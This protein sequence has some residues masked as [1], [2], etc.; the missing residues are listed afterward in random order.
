MGGFSF[1]EKVLFFFRKN[2]YNLKERSVARNNKQRKMSPSSDETANL[3]P[4]A[5]LVSACWCF[6]PNPTGRAG[7]KTP[8]CCGVLERTIDAMAK[9]EREIRLTVRVTPEEE[10]KIKENMTLTGT[11]NFSLYARKLLLDG[12]IVK[13][14]FAELKEVSAPLGQ[15]ARNLY[16]IAKRANETR[17]IYADDL[18]D[19]RK[20]YYKD[21]AELKERLIKLIKTIGK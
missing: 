18:E 2:Y 19:V 3:P 11:N 21:F 20:A 7:A 6:A 15:I 9:L 16:Q 4:A 8:Y 17:S 12:Y 10:A 13:L 5:F 14:D 1:Y